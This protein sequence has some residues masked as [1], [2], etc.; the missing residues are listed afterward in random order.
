MDDQLRGGHKEWGRD[1]LQETI[2]TKA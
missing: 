2:N 1:S